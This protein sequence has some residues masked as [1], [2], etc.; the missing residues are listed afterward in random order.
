MSHVRKI[1]FVRLFS[2]IGVLIACILGR[3]KRPEWFDVLDGWNF[4]TEFSPLHLLW[5]AI[6]D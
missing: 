3:I 2:R 6:K 5:V 1:Y 4:F